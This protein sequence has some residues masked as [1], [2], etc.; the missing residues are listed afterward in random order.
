MVPGAAWPRPHC[1]LATFGP[2][3]NPATGP[4]Y[5]KI[6]EVIFLSWVSSNGKFLG[7]FVDD[8]TYFKQTFNIPRTDFSVPLRYL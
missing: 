4:T 5:S 8:F 3:K 6:R 2:G 7:H 1:D